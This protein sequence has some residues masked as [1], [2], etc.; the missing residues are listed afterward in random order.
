M[1]ASSLTE[2]APTGGDLLAERTLRSGRYRASPTSAGAAPAGAV[3]Q[4]A[5][6]GGPDKSAHRHYER[7]PRDGLKGGAPGRR[8]MSPTAP[9][10]PLAGETPVGPSPPGARRSGFKNRR[11][12]RFDERR[13]SDYPDWRSS[14]AR[15][16][17]V[18]TRDE[19]EGET[20]I[21]RANIAREGE[22]VC[23]MAATRRG[24]PRELSVPA[25][26]EGSPSKRCFGSREREWTSPNLSLERTVETGEAG[27]RGASTSD[28]EPARP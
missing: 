17:L 3:S 28:C 27:F 5:S 23:V 18:F 24:P 26:D 19:N 9:A 16:P 2:G 6:S 10:R 1:P 11:G 22:P 14:S 25:Q 13:I 8:A 12:G 20:L 4:T 7:L 15:H 21:T